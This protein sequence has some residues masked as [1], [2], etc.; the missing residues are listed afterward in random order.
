AN[1]I[2]GALE[3]F[4]PDLFIVDKVPRGALRELDPTLELLH[5]NG[6]TRCV[7]G[8]RDVLDEPA[9]VRREWAQLEN[10][11]AVSRYY[12][13]V[14]GYG[15]PTVC[16]VARE[17]QFSPA[18]TEKV[19]YLGYLDQRNRLKDDSP[20]A[21]GLPDALG[22]PHGRLVLCLVGSGEDGAHLAETFAQTD[23]PPD[24]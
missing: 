9:I 12:H 23:L 18:V 24:T 22:L 17:Y 1:A 2:C 21:A 10:E 20:E 4:Q 7:L 6:R 16:D 11:D 19:R 14:W 8:L 13:A 5:A 3:A 15:D